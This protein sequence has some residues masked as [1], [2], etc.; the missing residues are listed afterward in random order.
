MQTLNFSILINAPR[1]KVWD[2][3]LSDVTYREW[4]APFSPAGYSSRFEGSWER[5]SKI[6]FLGVNAE[7][8]KEEGGM[9]SEIAENR[10]NEFIS[11][12]HI[13]E[14]KA[15]GSEVPW[16]ESTGDGFENYTLKETDS[17]TEVIID[18]I[19]IPEEYVQMMNDTWPKA[20]L[21]LKEVAER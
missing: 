7:T 18:V 16:P 11:I 17:G 5:G 1:E 10:P 19:G 4:T 15:D 8:G 21:K 12:K 2:A 14:I 6:R 3:M 9:Y 13:G 20:L